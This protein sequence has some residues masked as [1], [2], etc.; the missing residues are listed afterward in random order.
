MGVSLI[1]GRPV[2]LLSPSGAEIKDFDHP[3]IG[4]MQEQAG[5]VSGDDWENGLPETENK[6]IMS[7]LEQLG[8]QTHASADRM[9]AEYQS[10]LKGAPRT[11]RS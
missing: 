11:R 5:Y 3:D 10:L 6:P 8:R 4:E 9:H 1:K 7:G 2:E